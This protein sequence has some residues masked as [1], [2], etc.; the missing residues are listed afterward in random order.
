MPVCPSGCLPLRLLVF[1]HCFLLFL[2]RFVIRFLLLL[3]RLLGPAR[4][5]WTHEDLGLSW[6][7]PCETQCDQQY[8][9]RNSFHNPPGMEDSKAIIHRS[10]T[11]GC[12]RSM[13]YITPVTLKNWLIYEM[14]SELNLKVSRGENMDSRC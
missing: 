13:R 7:Q 4:T 12:P 3:A 8:E 9:S 10:C 6:C 1:L 14:S 5:V 2:G 11:Q